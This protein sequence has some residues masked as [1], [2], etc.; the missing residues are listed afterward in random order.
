MPAREAKQKSLKVAREHVQAS[1]NNAMIS[2]DTSVYIEDKYMRP[3]ITTEL[4]EQGY[5]IRCGS[6][7]TTSV[8]WDDLSSQECID[9]RLHIKTRKVHE[10]SIVQ[11]LDFTTVVDACV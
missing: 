2:G 1:I 8:S 4:V 7:T 3:S 11:Q 9:H 5:K 10:N 6:G